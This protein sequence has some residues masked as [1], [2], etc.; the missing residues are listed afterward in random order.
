MKRKPVDLDGVDA[1]SPHRL[2]RKRVTEH[3]QMSVLEKAA[4]TQALVAGELF[5]Y[6]NV[7]AWLA[8]EWA[9]HLREK[10]NLPDVVAVDAVSHRGPYPLPPKEKD[11]RQILK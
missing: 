4:V 11:S 1:Y 5:G 10:W 9:V 2:V 3:P 7:M 6:G 8:T